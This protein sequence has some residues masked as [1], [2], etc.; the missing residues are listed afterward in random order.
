M[1]QQQNPFRLA[2]CL[3]RKK[4]QEELGTGSGL[5]RWSIVG[6]EPGPTVDAVLPR[7]AR[8]FQHMIFGIVNDAC[9]T[10][11]I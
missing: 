2:L 1:R 8:D 9:V 7:N 3:S 10:D 11:P 4:T 6:D 5:A